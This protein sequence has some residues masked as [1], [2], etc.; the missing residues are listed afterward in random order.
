MRDFTENSAALS[1]PSTGMPT[2]NPVHGS[3]R[4]TMVGHCEPLPK[5]AKRTRQDNKKSQQGATVVLGGD[6]HQSRDSLGH[7]TQRSVISLAT[8]EDGNWLSEFM[9]Y[10]RSDLTEVFQAKENDVISRRNSKKVLLGQVGIRCR[11]CAHV[12]YEERTSR[13]SCY[14]SSLS[15]IYQSLTMMIREHFS[16]CLQMDPDAKERFLTLKGLSTQGAADSKHFWVSSAKAIGMR[17]TDKCGIAMDSGDASEFQHLFGRRRTGMPIM[18]PP[19]TVDADQQHRRNPD[20]AGLLVPSQ[21]KAREELCLVE[22]SDRPYASEL[23]FKLLSHTVRITMTQGDR[24]GNRKTMEAGAR[25]FACKF[26][27]AQGRLGQCRFFPT[28]KRTMIEK[29]K[30]DL[31]DHLQRCILCPREVQQELQQLRTRRD[32]ESRSASPS[33]EQQQEKE[34]LFF[35]QVWTRLMMA[36]SNDE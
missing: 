5:R 13:S 7:H 24:V 8:S 11:H 14:P 29:V 9:C 23:T 2:K 25:G 6:V 3:K 27:H 1:T 22:E 17:D 21:D 18:P 10:V 35:H 26:C 15:R 33:P 19:R 28:R 34:K 36:P 31:Y 12:P 32:D 4:R 16:K 20:Q 30:K